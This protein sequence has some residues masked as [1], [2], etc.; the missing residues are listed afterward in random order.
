MAIAIVFAEYGDPQVLRP[1]DIDPPTAA[2]GQV[3]VQVKA[4]GVN[5]VDVKLRRGDFAAAMPVDFPS[6]IGNE[7]A[8]IIDQV[9]D[10]VTGFA[11][12][13]HVLGSATG[14]CY[15][16]YV[17]VDAADVVAKPAGIPWTVAA[18]LPAVGQT[19]HTALR[20]IVVRAGD[21][22]LIHAA[23]GGVG[24]IATQLARLWG[25]AVIG[26]A[27]ERNHNYLRS[28]GAT[29]VV[30]GD[31]LVERVHALAPAGVDAALDAI[32]GE[33]I[34]VSL[35]LVPDHGRIGTLVDAEA[36]RT[37]GIQRVG[38]RSTVALRELVTLYD[39]GSLQ[40]PIHA[41][42][43]LTEAHHAHHEVQ[44]GHVRGKVVLTMP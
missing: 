22:V 23:A 1:I 13:D 8:G 12:G 26:T 14:Q 20:Q 6:R 43:P 32:G 44:T 15:A 21:T 2:A 7:Y 18:G 38:G 9:G 27:S 3:R 5:P 31:G 11:V 34:T 25:A 39:Q 29:P 17:V 40:L 33:A 30:Y 24:T 35:A 37:H 19:A 10:E 41:T 42:F 36:A 16:E 28:L 4:A